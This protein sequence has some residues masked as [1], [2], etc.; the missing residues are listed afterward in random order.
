MQTQAFYAFAGQLDTFTNNVKDGVV[1]TNF[2]I[3]RLA[4]FDIMASSTM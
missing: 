1:Q 3:Q 2:A 4:T